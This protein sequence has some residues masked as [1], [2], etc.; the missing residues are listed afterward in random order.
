[1]FLFSQIILS[2]YITDNVRQ[3]LQHYSVMMS[4]NNQLQ[5]IITVSIIY[6]FDKINWEG[7][8]LIS[9]GN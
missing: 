4:L 3:N 9:N 1:M 2:F 6:G 7:F 5:S 8:K